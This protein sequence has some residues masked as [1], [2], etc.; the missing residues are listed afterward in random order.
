MSTPHNAFTDVS[1]FLHTRTFWDCNGSTLLLFTAI[2]FAAILLLLFIYVLEQRDKIQQNW[3]TEQC[4]P[5]VIPFAGWLAP[6]YSGDKITAASQSKFCMQQLA[7]V[8]VQDA[9][10]PAEMVIKDTKTLYTDIDDAIK[11]SANMMNTLGTSVSSLEHTIESMVVNA[12]IELHKMFLSIQDILGKMQAV[13]VSAMYMMLGSYDTLQSLMGA[14][15][16]MTVRLLI[17]LAVLIAVM[18]ILPV[19]WPAAAT[20]TAFFTAVAI[21]LSILIYFMENIMHVKSGTFGRIPTLQTKNSK[22]RCFVHD[23]VVALWSNQDHNTTTTTKYVSELIPGDVLWDGSVVTSVQCITYVH[24]VD[25]YCVPFRTTN[26]RTN[27]RTNSGENEDEND[28]FPPLLFVSGDHLCFCEE[29]N[30]WVPIS[31]LKTATFMYKCANATTPKDYLYCFTTT[32]HRI[33]LHPNQYLQL[34]DWDELV[35]TGDIEHL[36]FFFDLVD[37]PYNREQLHYYIHPDRCST[38]VDNTTNNL[39][40]LVGTVQFLTRHGTTSTDRLL[41]DNQQAPPLHGTDFDSY[42]DRILDREESG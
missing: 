32:T 25:I 11:D 15:L 2:T 13:M 34:A 37:T 20:S 17:M 28:M 22:P 18:W 1:I 35:F 7:S 31:S 24:D 9:L 3:K 12:G 30:R 26:N 36:L 42:V 10:L 16:E 4:K 5:Y 23:T 27:D 40:P 29:R 14:V 8:V 6:A 39:N 19:T 33:S 41:W 21:P 38:D